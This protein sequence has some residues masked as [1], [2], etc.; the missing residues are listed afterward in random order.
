[1]LPLQIWKVAGETYKVKLDYQPWLS[2]RSEELCTQKANFFSGLKFID[3]VLY[4]QPNLYK[5][6]YLRSKYIVRL[7]Q[8][9]K[10]T[11]VTSLSKV[12]RMKSYIYNMKLRI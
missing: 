4:F 1:M 11:K 9:C 6:K 3:N 5:L 7:K 12:A 2:A 10:V 8:N